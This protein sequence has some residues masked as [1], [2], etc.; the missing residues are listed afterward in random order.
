MA[1]RSF[2]ATLCA[3]SI[4]FG[5]VG[6]TPR[7]RVTANPTA[8][9][10]GIRYYRPK[11]YLK[12]VPAE[13]RVAKDASRIEPGLVTITLEYLPDFTEEYAV[14]VRPGFGVANVS[15]TLEDGWNL[16]EINQELDSQTDENLSAAG[17][18]MKAVS[19]LVPTAADSPE[20]QFT[21]PATDVPLG[22][23]ES[24]IGRGPDGRKRLYGFRYLGF[25]PYQ[26]CPTVMGGI[27]AACCGDPLSPLYGLTFEGGRMVFKPLPTLA[28]PPQG[29][30]TT[31]AVLEPMEVAV[32]TADRVTDRRESAAV[33]SRIEI[34]LRAELQRS[35]PAVH[36]VTIQR[37][38]RDG[39]ERM[40]V[41]VRTTDEAAS[42]PVASEAIRRLALEKLGEWLPNIA[43][44]VEIE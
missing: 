13:I 30:I 16:T 35:Y 38:H 36:Q 23:Y 8:E 10:N 32:P 42:D 20:I 29:T 37:E 19:G 43:S 21:V 34:D 11:P 40:F 15:L 3:A 4:L 25:L 33:A 28:A 7:I 27:D 26:S 5:T 6:C 1:S 9:T 31:A 17:D 12:I 2:L 18:L 22:F 39:A 41:R 24:V 44:D 14:D